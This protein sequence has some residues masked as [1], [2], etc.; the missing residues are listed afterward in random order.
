MHTHL[1][2]R[3][4]I[5]HALLYFV[6]LHIYFFSY[7]CTSVLHTFHLFVLIFGFKFGL[8]SL[9]NGIS[10]CIGYLVAQLFIDY[11]YLPKPLRMQDVT[12]NQF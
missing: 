11:M 12:Q 10:T 4:K 5:F 8:V 1:F 3:F 6:T 9:F 2:I 7:V